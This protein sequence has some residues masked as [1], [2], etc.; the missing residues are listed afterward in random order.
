MQK[1]E[2]NYL[3][4]RLDGT[5]QGKISHTNSNLEHGCSRIIIGKTEHVLWAVIRN[6]VGRG[7]V[8][9]NGV[10]HEIR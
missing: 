3:G 4:T 5:H 7:S 9:I 2:F 6:Y 10:N 8:S 1:Y